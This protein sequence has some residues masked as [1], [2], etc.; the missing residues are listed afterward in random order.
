M[1]SCK[2]S[3][4][5]NKFDRRN[6]SNFLLLTA[7]DI[8]YRFDSRQYVHPVLIETCCR[9]TLQLLQHPRIVSSKKQWLLPLGLIFT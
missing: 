3:C 4:Y 2:G 5:Y 1:Q 6:S 9:S 7:S 8:Q